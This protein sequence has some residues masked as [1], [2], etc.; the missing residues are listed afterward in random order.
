MTLRKKKILFLLVTISFFALRSAEQQTKVPRFIEKFIK[1]ILPT[2]SRGD[3]DHFITNLDYQRDYLKAMGNILDLGAE[4]C[5]LQDKNVGFGSDSSN[6]LSLISDF[7]VGSNFGLYAFPKGSDLGQYGAEGREILTQDTLFMQVPE[8]DPQAMA[9]L[10]TLFNLLKQS[11]DVYDELK[12]AVKYICNDAQAGH[13]SKLIAETILHMHLRY[14]LLKQIEGLDSL[15]DLSYPLD[16][17]HWVTL[18]EWLQQVR[19]HCVY[20]AV[21]QSFMDNGIR[22]LLQ[23][24]QEILKDLSNSQGRNMSALEEY[25]LLYQSAMEKAQIFS[26]Q[27]D[28]SYASYIKP[29]VLD[30]KISLLEI[31]R[32]EEVSKGETDSSRLSRKQKKAELEALAAEL[33][34]MDKKKR[35]EKKSVP[36]QAPQL[37]KK[38][39]VERKEMPTKI[40]AAKPVPKKETQWAP[41]AIGPATFAQGWQMVQPGY[42]IPRHSR[43]VER[44]REETRDDELAQRRIYHDFPLEF[45]GL[46]VKE[47]VQSKMPNATYPQQVDT[48]YTLGGMIKYPDGHVETIVYS[49]TKGADDRVYHRG[50]A[51]MDAKIF[52]HSYS[53]NNAWKTTFPNWSEAEMVEYDKFVHQRPP[54]ET[55]IERQDNYCMYMKNKE[56]GIEYII[57]KRDK[58]KR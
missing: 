51:R 4:L 52:I 15:K 32:P 45:D 34:G 21:D 29:D 57:Y 16:R 42:Q 1:K 46:L 37:V 12:V 49:I 14:Q 38:Q 43:R 11:K 9:V 58:K 56:T 24:G 18:F 55:F 2:L 3:L 50:I 30:R 47:G 53:K 25:D 39:E 23:K 40:P 7:T 33:E 6:A 48:Q 36:K 54:A 17:P 10:L 13:M 19:N 26:D 5:A 31:K 41:Q 22:K 8:D 27:H 20:N 44:R 28:V 35:P